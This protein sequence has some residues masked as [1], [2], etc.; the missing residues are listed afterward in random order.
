MDVVS[1]FAPSPSAVECPVAGG[2]IVVERS[3]ELAGVAAL[4]L[5]LRVV[6]GHGRIFA[7]RLVDCRELAVHLDAVV[8]PHHEILS[9]LANRNCRHLRRRRRS[10]GIDYGGRTGSDNLIFHRDRAGTNDRICGLNAPTG[11]AYRSGPGS[12]ENS[13][14]IACEANRTVSGK[15]YDNRTLDERRSG[16]M[17]ESPA[18]IVLSA[19]AGGVLLRF[20][21]SCRRSRLVGGGDAGR[22]G[23]GGR[24]RAVRTGEIH[25]VVGAAPGSGIRGAGPFATG[26]KSGGCGDCGKNAEFLHGKVARGN[27]DCGM[28]SGRGRL[29]VNQ[30]QNAIVFL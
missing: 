23:G 19:S 27:P 11:A 6:C 8:E 9:V 3:N 16:K 2:D 21:V 20:G 10:R 30:S 1:A 4:H 13:G 22:L 15:R 28:Q 18:E 17:A 29:Y 24:R 7:A 25:V 26:K 5:E 14:I 12:C